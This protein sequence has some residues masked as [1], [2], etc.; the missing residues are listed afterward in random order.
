MIKLKKR[1]AAIL[2]GI[3]AITPLQSTGTYK[4]RH[5]NAATTTNFSTSYYTEANIT[6]KTEK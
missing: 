4:L 3:L 2:I 6:I 1:V 5:V